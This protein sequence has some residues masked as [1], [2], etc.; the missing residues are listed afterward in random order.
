[1][2]HPLRTGRVVIVLLLGLGSVAATACSE[3]VGT[4]T[5][6]TSAPCSPQTPD[7]ARVAPTL[8]LPLDGTGDR[9]V[10]LPGRLPLPLLVHAHHDGAGSFV[11]TGVDASSKATQV[12]A[13]TLGKYDG[14]FAVG[15][16]DAC[17]TPTAA[18]HIA[19]SGK[20][21][22]DFANAKLAPKYDDTKGVA[23]RGDAV[24][25]YVGRSTRVRITYAGTE[26]KEPSLRSHD[27]FEVTTYGAKRPSLLAQSNGAYQATVVLPPGPV[28]I[29]VTARGRWTIAR[30]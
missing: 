29:A 24:L 6:P 18:L 21:H 26:S 27:A 23:G 25:S 15:F 14:T 5:T 17:A 11:V 1:V 22:L 10:G 20:W 12:L 28:F 7:A 3:S 30:A 2:K 13:S 16:V 4:D 9:T 19:T 8:V